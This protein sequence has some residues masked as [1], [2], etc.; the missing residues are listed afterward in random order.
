MENESVDADSLLVRTTKLALEQAQFET[1]MDL[2]LATQLSDPDTVQLQANGMT[3]LQNLSHEEQRDA[4]FDHV[5]KLVRTVTAMEASEP[6]ALDVPFDM[7]GL[8]SLLT[9]D[10]TD[11]LN[12]SLGLNLSANIC[13]DCPTIEL[14]V[15]H[16]AKEIAGKTAAA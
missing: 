14:L 15:N 1:K 13:I 6:L 11:A 9:L 10:L 12:N 2:S 4:L 7:L 8:D 16:L 3:A 5:V